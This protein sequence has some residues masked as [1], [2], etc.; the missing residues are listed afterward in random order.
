MD[1]KEFM[2]GE[3]RGRGA[4]KRKSRSKWS[5]KQSREQEAYLTSQKISSQSELHAELSSTGATCATSARE[6]ASALAAACCCNLRSL[7]SN[8]DLSPRITAL[9]SDS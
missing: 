2:Q 4:H 3:E 5:R 6:A 7:V 1:R 8:S 9:L